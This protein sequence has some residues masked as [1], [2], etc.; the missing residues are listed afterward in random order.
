MTRIRQT[1]LRMPVDPYLLLLL[2]TVALGLAFPA[3]GSSQSLVNNLAYGAVSGLFFLYG[4]HLAPSAVW[5]GMSNWR[6]QGLV[7]ASTF[8]LFPAIGV[9]IGHVAKPYLPTALASGLVFLTLLPSTVQS[10]IAFT[11]IAR[12]DVPAALCSASFSNIVG[13]FLTPILVSLTFPGRYGLSA[14][15]VE[16]VGLQILLPF[17]MGQAARPFIGN[18][19]ERH[20]VLTAI[21]DRGSILVIVYSA[22][23][24]GSANGIWQ[25]VSP[26]VLLTVLLLDVIMLGAVIVTTTLTS[27]WLAFTIEE[28]IAIV[29]C[30]SKKSMASGLPIANILFPG[31]SVGLIVLPLMIFHQ[32]QLFVCASLARR[33]ARRTDDRYTDHD[34]ISADH[35]IERRALEKSHP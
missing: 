10:S 7:F 1:L 16:G 11:S 5:R 4:A 30:G 14:G 13:V 17:A 15:S 26:G 19:L 8:M 24:E 33:Y 21:F 28:E 32:L 35:P 27:R 31:H 12:G 2:G 29:F 34:D 25:L 3:T 20:R 6:L 23:S 9:A 18:W 22:F